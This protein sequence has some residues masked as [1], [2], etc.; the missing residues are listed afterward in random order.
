MLVV[1]VGVQMTGCL[2]D[3]ESAVLKQ[4]M[5]AKSTILAL[6]FSP[7]P[8]IPSLL[9]WSSTDL[10]GPTSPL[11]D[12]QGSAIYAE[13]LLKVSWAEAGGTTQS[14]KPQREDATVCWTL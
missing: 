9:S 1:L 8:A 12:I 14:G 3:A 13:H 10:D 2:T 5:D 6:L 4:K 11:K 7:A